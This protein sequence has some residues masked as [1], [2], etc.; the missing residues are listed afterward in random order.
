MLFRS[1]MLS[2]SGLDVV[3]LSK[4]KNSVVTARCRKLGVQCIQACDEKLFSLQKIAKN[5]GLEAG[6]VAYVGNDVN[7]LECMR[8]VGLPIAVADGLEQAKQMAKW[9]TVRAGGRGAVRDICD[10]LLSATAQREP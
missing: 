10:L 4:E 8:W 6:Q 2:R 7:D 1:E 3:V 9:V 5:K